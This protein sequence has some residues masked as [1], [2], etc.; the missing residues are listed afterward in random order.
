[1]TILS[2]VVASIIAFIFGAG[3]YMGP[4]G[5]VWIN[6][7]IWA[8]ENRAMTQKGKYMARM[9]G[10]S[11]VLTMVTAYVLSVFFQ[12]TGVTTLT[13]YLQMAMLL[14]FGFVIVT[15][16]NDLVYT[17]TPPFWS[18]RAQMTFIIDAGYYIGVFAIIASVLYYL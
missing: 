7:K 5:K 16:F 14:C 8:E 1:M 10:M 15:K 2:I 13:E 18:R 6:S 3:W 17:N 4:I 12:I 9:Y 11:F